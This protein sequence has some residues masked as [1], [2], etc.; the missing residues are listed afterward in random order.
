VTQQ[1]GEVAD[2][3]PQGIS[4]RAFLV[5]LSV[6]VL[7]MSCLFGGPLYTLTAGWVYFIARVGPL[8]TFSVSGVFTALAAVAFF[9]VGLHLALR[10]LYVSTGS[11]VTAAPRHWRAKWTATIAALVILTFASG[12]A[13]LG[14]IH[15]IGWLATAPGPLTT[16]HSWERARSQNNL[17]QI[18]L[19]AHNYHDAHNDAFPPG[20]TTNDNGRL[21]HG[22]YAHL[23]PYIEEEVLFARIQFDKPWDDEP[24]RPALQTQIGVYHSPR[25]ADKSDASGYA[26][27][28][29]AGNVNTFPGNRGLS[30]KGGFP[31]GTSNTLM[32]GEV[33]TGFRPWG[34]P[35]NLRDPAKGLR[36]SAETFCGPWAGGITQFALV[37]GSV[38][39]IS[40]SISPSV[41]KALSTPAG[42]ERIEEKDW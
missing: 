40:P 1:V 24:N 27:T 4:L 21:L 28:H 32:F 41:L 31:D 5:V 10:W 20:F 14:V 13:A 22:L 19:A 29:Y 30:L 39:K 9:V 33:N 38:R 25:I 26:V 34:H 35:L 8:I 16:D 3:R 18:I 37:D 17:K 42:G 11:T 36:S 15:Q 6:I 23:L 7:A 12:I 2:K